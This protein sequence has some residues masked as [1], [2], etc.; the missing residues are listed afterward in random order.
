M[1]PLAGILLMILTVA[2]ILSPLVQQKAAP[3]T[4]GP[5]LVAELRELYALR[6][7]A[8]ETIRDLEQDYHAG[9]IDESDYRE[10][11]ERHKGEALELIRR[12][13]ALEERLPGETG[14]RD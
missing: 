2:V 14:R 1:L 4:D 13:E 9:K 5:D 10:L 7:V 12:I 8:Y 6:D 3:L 11:T